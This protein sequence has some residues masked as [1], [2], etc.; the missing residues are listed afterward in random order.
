MSLISAETRLVKGPVG[1]LEAV[2]EHPSDTPK[3]L[4]LVAH[5]NPL[6]GG[7]LQNKVTQRLA[8]TLA[9]LGYTT[10][11]MNC[12]GVG[13][14]QGSYDHGNG[15]ADDWRTIYALARQQCPQGPL[16]LAGFSFGAFVMSEVAR[17]LAPHQLILVAPAVGHFPLGSVPANTLVIHG[18]L[19][20]TVPL[21]D[22]LRWAEP[23]GLPI[24]V[25]PGGDHFFHQRLILLR[26]WVTRFLSA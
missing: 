19:D 18:E 3:G 26:D 15:E 20:T 23:Q 2:I 14:S 7:N 16:L 1:L 25:V 4:A 13:Q 17:H 6:F 12:R 8:R 22:V 11:R 24:L 21:H 5:P 10:W 9:D